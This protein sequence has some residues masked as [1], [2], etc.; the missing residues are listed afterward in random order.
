MKKKRLLYH[1]TNQ[2]GY[3]MQGRKKTEFYIYGTKGLMPFIELE[4]Q[5]KGGWKEIA[6]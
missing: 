5:K 6:Y 1:S 3:D 2:M 4:G